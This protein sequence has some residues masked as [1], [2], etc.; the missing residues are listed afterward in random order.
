MANSVTVTAVSTTSSEGGTV[1]LVSGRITYNPPA[2]FV[3]SDSF[4]YTIADDGDSNGAPDRIVYYESRKISRTEEDSNKD[5]Q[6]DTWTVFTDSGIPQS[7]RMKWASW[8]CRSSIGP[9][10]RL[11]S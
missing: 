7:R 1:S 8:T 11:G 3:G 9:P 2:N 5:G 4:T 10:T 6:M